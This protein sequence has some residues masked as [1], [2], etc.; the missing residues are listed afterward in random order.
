MINVAQQWNRCL[1]VIKANLPAEQFDVWFA[2]IV[3]VDFDQENDRVTL[4]YSAGDSLALLPVNSISQPR[5]S[6]SWRSFLRDSFPGG[7]AD[8]GD[9]THRGRKNHMDRSMLCRRGLVNLI[10]QEHS[11]LL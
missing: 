4:F 8:L 9:P 3:A 2:P 5:R 1:D 10:S 6:G 11:W 7:V